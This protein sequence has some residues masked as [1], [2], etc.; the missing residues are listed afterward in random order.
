MAKISL[1]Q[2]RHI[3]ILLAVFLAFFAWSYIS[4]Y[5]AATK[6]SYS[7]FLEQVENGNVQ[8]I[9]VKGESIEGTLREEASYQDTKYTGFSTYFPSFGD[10]ELMS[11]LKAQEVEVT[12]EPKTDRVFWYI[13]ISLLP[14]LLIFSLIYIQYRRMQGQGGGGGPFNIG[15]SQARKYDQSKEKTTF[16]DVAGS[17]EAKVE[18]QEVV[19]YLTE[20][21]RI[22]EMGGK[23]PKG[24]MLVGP[25]GTGK[26][27]LA[28]AVAGE[29]GVPFFSITGSDFMEM[30]VGVGAKRVRN[31]FQDARK[32]APCIIFIDEIDAI[33]RRRG[34]GLGGGHDEREQ[35]LNQLLSELDGFEAHENIIVICATNRPDI[36]DPALTRPGR[37]DRQ[38]IVDLPTTNDRLEL[39]QLYTRDKRLSQEVD[40]ERLA[41]E[42]QGFSGADLENML[43][44]ATLLAAREGQKSITHNEIESA[45]DKIL[46]GLKRHGLVM[47]DA[48]R[49]LVA[50]HE[51]GHALVGAL[52]PNADPVHKVSIVPRSQSMGATQQFPEQDRYIYPREYLHDRLAVMMG[53]RCAESLVFETATS[54]AANDLQQATKMARKM[55]LEW[56]MGGQF[57]H[58]ALGSP[59]E[60]VFLGEELGKTKE[61]SEATSQAVDQEVESILKNAFEQAKDVL[62]RH[63]Q[64]LDQLAQTLLDQEEV[65]GQTVYSIAGIAKES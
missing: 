19:D 13:I 61:Y 1:Q 37:F 46:M 27:L 22:Q 43:N 36:L 11:E 56:G 64:A 26:T 2:N 60:Q 30:F 32:N 50:Y 62:S 63:R 34:A 14:M 55:V 58:M 39:L 41:R 29:A 3:F 5:K 42:T 25:P 15:K 52:L 31:L 8:E 20:P 7:E 18:L 44:E 6:I 9:T 23:I 53:G 40:L 21:G 38:I 47:T 48:E 65:D 35:T 57:E 24:L 12:T 59:G 17:Q 54:G 49:R 33:G 28:R 4:Q 16:D 45:R 10:Q 51:A